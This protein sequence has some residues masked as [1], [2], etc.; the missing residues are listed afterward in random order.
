MQMRECLDVEIVRIN[1]ENVMHKY[2]QERDQVYT[3]AHIKAGRT[4]MTALRRLVA[5]SKVRKE[6]GGAEVER[7]ASLEKV[8]GVEE[9]KKVIQ[10][11]N[12]NPY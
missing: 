5:E 8:K 10:G 12:V 7:K 3:S 4:I 9:A 6:Q 11:K 1:E 2:H